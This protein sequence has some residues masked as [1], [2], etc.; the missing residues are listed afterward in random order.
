MGAVQFIFW[1]ANNLYTILKRQTSTSSYPGT[2]EMSVQ[3]S[4]RKRRT[5]CQG[6]AEESKGEEKPWFVLSF[7]TAHKQSCTYEM[8]IGYGAPHMKCMLILHTY[9]SVRMTLPRRPPNSNRAVFSLRHAR[10]ACQLSSRIRGAET[11]SAIMR[12][13]SAP[14]AADP[15]SWK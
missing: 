13:T 9:F 1:F 11:S 15:Q 2:K 3:L 14:A 7:C 5:L 8:L 4:F 10:C 6:K 12:R